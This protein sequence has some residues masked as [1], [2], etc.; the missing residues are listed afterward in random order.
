M[1][2]GLPLLAVLLVC[3]ALTFRGPARTGGVTAA[4]RSDPVS[5]PS[6]PQEREYSIKAQFLLR[7]IKYTTWPKSSFEKKDA[8][9]VVTV[10]GKDPFGKVLEE[11]FEDETVHGRTVEIGRSSK[12]PEDLEGHVVF[13]GKLEDEERA[14]LL[15]SC[16]GEPVLLV[17]DTP[18]LAAA[19]ASINFFLR[20]GKIAFEINID[21]VREASLKISP[22]VLKLAKIVRSKGEDK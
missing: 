22:A 15:K 4:V 21:A 3:L 16:R 13:C 2:L 17:G 1:R 19:G 6:E 9:L 12:V 7:M 10:I 8:P 5:E 14:R 11:T 20:D 18:G